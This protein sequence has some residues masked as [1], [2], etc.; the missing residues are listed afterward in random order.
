MDLIFSVQYLPLPVHLQQQQQL[1]CPSARQSV[2]AMSYDEFQSLH[3]SPASAVLCTY[4]PCTRPWRMH[5]HTMFTLHIK[6]SIQLAQ[7][8]THPASHVS[9]VTHSPQGLKSISKV[10]CFEMALCRWIDDEVHGYSKK[11]HSG[12]PDLRS[13]VT[14]NAMTPG[15]CNNIISW[16]DTAHNLNSLIHI[17]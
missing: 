10:K 13:C 11:R 16:K 6:M 9:L 5:A 1:D 12:I 17:T 15:V 7:S 3:A 4:H 2:L 14:E 8:E